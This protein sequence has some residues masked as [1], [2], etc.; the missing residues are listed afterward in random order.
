MTKEEIQKR[1]VELCGMVG[2]LNY[3]LQ[4]IPKDLEAAYK[5]MAELNQANAKLQQEEKDAQNISKEA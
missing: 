1:Y 4:A 5:E 3:R 2:D